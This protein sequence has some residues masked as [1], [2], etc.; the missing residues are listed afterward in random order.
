MLYIPMVFMLLATLTSLVLTFINKVKAIA[1]GAGDMAAWLQSI[2]S[3][4]LFVLALILVVEG[5]QALT[6]K[7]AKN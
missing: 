2:F 4:I 5:V 7:K 6:K 1:G 3:V